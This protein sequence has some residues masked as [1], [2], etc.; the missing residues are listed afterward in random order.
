MLSRRP[1]GGSRAAFPAPTDIE[2]E[3]LRSRRVAVVGRTSAVRERYYA[4]SVER[5]LKHAG[6]AAITNAARAE[7]F[8]GSG[9]RPR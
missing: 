9:V 5:R 1:A 4:I 2:G 6:V 7:V 3:L 8:R